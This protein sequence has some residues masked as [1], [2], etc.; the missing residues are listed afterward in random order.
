MKI[1][2]L[3]AGKAN[4]NTLNGVNKVVHNIATEQTNS[5]NDVTVLGVAD[6][7]IIRHKHNYHLVLFKKCI[8][9]LFPPYRLVLYFLRCDKKSIVHLHSAFIVWFPILILLFKIIGISYVLTPHGAY[10]ANNLKLSKYKL[11]YFHLIDWLILYNA[12]K[13]QVIGRSEINSYTSTYYKDKAVNIP[14]GSYSINQSVKIVN[15]VMQLGYLGRLKIDHKGLDILIKGF[16]DYRR[17]GGEAILNLVGSGPDEIIL[18]KLVKKLKLESSV[19]FLGVKF[20]DDKFSF[21]NNLS[22][23]IHTSRWEGLPTACIES[24]SVGTPILVSKETNIN[25]LVNE[26]NIGFVL[27]N[28]TPNMVCKYLFE[29]ERILQTKEY[30]KMIENSIHLI[31]NDLNWSNISFNI[32]KKLYK[33]EKKVS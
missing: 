13:I 25:S 33:V 31:K 11:L 20:D 23:F 21:L 2:H 8:I 19:N 30:S 14:N 10:S 16:Y 12:K 18:K 17:K 26:Y 29:M 27:D 4:P 28:N 5:K 6:N 9:N 1:I 3:I 7:K 15:E 32:I 24:L 22:Y